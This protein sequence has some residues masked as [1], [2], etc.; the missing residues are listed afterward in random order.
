MIVHRNAS[1]QR[2]SELRLSDYRYKHRPNHV[3]T[4]LD[5]FL[6]GKGAQTAIS[7]LANSEKNEFISP[8]WQNTLLP[9]TKII[10]Q[11]T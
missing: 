4:V 11:L 2:L 5:Q 6:R 7:M 9:L 8:L 1:I 10:G 3:T